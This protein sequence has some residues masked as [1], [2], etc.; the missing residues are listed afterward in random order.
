MISELP[1]VRHVPIGNVASGS[2]W[3]TSGGMLNL[4]ICVKGTFALG[5]GGDMALVAPQPARREE[6][7]RLPS[8]TVVAP[9]DLVPQ[10]PH[11]EVTLVGHAH[12]A[13]GSPRSSARLMLTCGGDTVLDKRIELVGERV[14]GGEAAPFSKLRLSYDLALG[15]IGFADNPLG[16]GRDD[17]AA[18][19]CLLHPTEPQTKVACFAP[20]PAAFMARRR[21]LGGAPHRIFSEPV[22]H[23][24]SD[25]DWTY[26]QSAPEDQWL[27]ALTGEEWLWLEGM[28]PG[29]R[30][31][32]ARLPSVR[33]AGRVEGAPP[34]GLIPAELPLRA[35]SLHIDVDTG[36][37]TLVWRTSF[38]VELPVGPL[39]IGAALSTGG[40]PV[41]WPERLA[42]R[43]A[44]LEASHAVVLGDVTLSI[45]EDTQPL[46]G[47]TTTR[48][49]RPE[50]SETLPF[51]EGGAPRH[52]HA[53]D[54]FPIPGAPWSGETAPVVSAPSLGAQ[55]LTDAAEAEGVLARASDALAEEVP[56]DLG[57][58][59]PAPPAAPPSE[60]AGARAREADAARARREQQAAAFAREQA[61]AREA[62]ARRTARAEEQR[63]EAERLLADLYG[64]FKR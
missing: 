1:D 45:V 21:R 50:R 11:P 10:L 43:P 52:P 34:G 24:P 51:D 19:P 56:S 31:F 13:N 55:T 33:A 40:A 18:L 23:I 39:V 60:G 61:E 30:H 7:T 16:R 53:G 25:F 28:M 20:L 62:E 41:V 47:L 3:W 4:T 49:M 48:E 9:A 22:V 2:L 35:E 29:R 37:V 6:L 44:P 5:S 26:F 12:N 32:R 57:T 58:E 14:P 15:G 46:A 27:P 54:A 17:A 63:R 38:P 42:P 8:L 36:L 59:P 64:G